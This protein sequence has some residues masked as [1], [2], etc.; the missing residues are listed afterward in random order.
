[1]SQMRKALE[2]LTLECPGF[3]PDL[4]YKSK[5]GDEDHD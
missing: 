4:E 1:M 2:A 3:R 5:S